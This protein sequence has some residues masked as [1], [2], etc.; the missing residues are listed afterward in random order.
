MTRRLAWALGAATALAVP[1]AS[2]STAMMT[3]YFDEV[4]RAAYDKEEPRDALQAFLLVDALT[5]TPLSAFNV[6]LVAD[7][8]KERELAF[9]YLSRYLASGDTDAERRAEATRRMGALRKRLALVRV[10]SSPPGATIY[11][12]RRALGAYGVTPATIVVEP[13][14]HAIDL[15]HPDF[16]PGKAQARARRGAEA[17]TELTLAPRTG[18]LDVSASAK[19]T[20][21]ARDATG[22]VHSLEFGRRAEL[23]VGR[24][25]VRL[26]APLHQP[27]EADVVVREGL[28]ASV[29][30]APTPLPPPTGRLLVAT[31]GVRAQVWV[32]GKARS[33]T[34]ATIGRLAVGDHDVE[35]RAPGHRPWR[36]R[37]TIREEKAVFLEPKLERGAP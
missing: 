7:L 35:V 8:A 28:V 30:L 34:P 13:G 5:P 36:Q 17:K 9:A 32:D 22:K 27:E 25:R 20:L 4:A 31:K 26:E 21:Q 19:G 1:G 24:Y 33:S 6:G 12:D 29:A 11:V 23:P 10:E 16:L 37:V 2:A 18:G 14:D 3:R 15:D